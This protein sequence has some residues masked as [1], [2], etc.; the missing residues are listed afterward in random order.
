M[1]ETS[2][3]KRHGVWMRMVDMAHSERACFRRA[4]KL[5]ERF[6]LAKIAGMMP[7]CRLTVGTPELG[8]TDEEVTANGREH[9]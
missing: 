1:T 3:M 5:N 2:V 6:G 7:V 8:R 9:R 4:D